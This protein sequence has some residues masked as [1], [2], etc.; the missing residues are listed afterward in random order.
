MSM[1]PV[2]A[3]LSICIPKRSMTPAQA[4]LRICSPQLAKTTDVSIKLKKVKKK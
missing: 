4:L 2:Q 3:L 1:S